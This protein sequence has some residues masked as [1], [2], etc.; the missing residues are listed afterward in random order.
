[1]KKFAKINLIVFIMTITGFTIK[2]CNTTNTIT[3]KIENKDLESKLNKT[4]V[5]KSIE[6]TNV[7][8]AFKED[9]PSLMFDFTNH[10][11]SGNSGC[12]QFNGGFALLGNLYAPTPLITTRMICPSK[13]QESKLLDLLAK[14]S[15]LIF[16]NYTLQFVQNGKV[17]LEFIPK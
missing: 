1:M 12:N 6:Q 9:I 14:K 5:L 3:D 10:T 17:V 4:W 13:N 15:T 16:N 8:D 2:S 7:S 11:V